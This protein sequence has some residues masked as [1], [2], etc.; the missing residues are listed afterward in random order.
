MKQQK[1]NKAIF[2]LLMAMAAGIYLWYYPLDRGTVSVSVGLS[3]YLLITQS[4]TIQC[5]TDPCALSQKTGTIELKIQKDG[6]FPE[7]SK[8]K[9][10]RFKTEALI[11]QLK[12]VP[13]LK[14]SLVA[15]TES[16]SMENKPLS[17][18]L[19]PTSISTFV[20]DSKGER[21]AYLDKTDEKV[22]IWSDG[23]A[24][25]ITP[26]KNIKEGFKFL[27]SPSGTLLAGLVGNELY[28]IDTQKASRK[29]IMI[30]FEP[31]STLWDLGGGAL[32]INESQDKIY[33]LDPQSDKPTPL[34]LKAD[35]RNAVWSTDGKLIY[36]LVDEKANQMKVLAYDPTA[37]ESTEIVSR[38][39]FPVSKIT[40]DV[41][42]AIYFYNPN[43][44]NW[45][46][47]EY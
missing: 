44:K 3:D 45:S 32:L 47:L 5:P 25:V 46:V 21:L 10:R 1:K 4:Q 36:F 2:I 12:K 14:E 37:N 16:P 6:Y 31:Q 13:T 40:R 24:K 22:K 8:V 27:W 33:K 43:L 30:G 23:T 17:D 34:S 29:K 7:T 20:W 38:Y 19:D 39:D 9:I 28:F 41:S 35:L 11:V 18:G 26:L 42:G 15:P